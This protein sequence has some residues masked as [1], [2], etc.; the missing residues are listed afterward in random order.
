VERGRLEAMGEAD[1]PVTTDI[2]RLIRVPGSL[3]GKTGLKV[4]ELSIDSFRNFEPLEQAVA[5]GDGDVTVHLK[6]PFSMTM[7]GVR[8]D[9]NA[10]RNTVPEHLAVFLIAR[11]TATLSP[12]E[13]A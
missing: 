3:H 13:E 8:H 4:V 10:G 5:F 2:K 1:E 7:R 9:L 11:R 12:P 6:E